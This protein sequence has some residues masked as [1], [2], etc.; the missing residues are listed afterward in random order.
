M[1]SQVFHESEVDV[2][3]ESDHLQVNSQGFDESE[4]IQVTQKDLMR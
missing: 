4:H 2:T 3:D 1:N